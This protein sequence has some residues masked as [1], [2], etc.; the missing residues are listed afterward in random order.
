MFNA[1]KRMK[2]IWTQNSES[3]IPSNVFA[4]GRDEHSPNELE[5]T[6]CWRLQRRT[7]MHIHLAIHISQSFQ[8][9]KKHCKHCKVL[10]R[11]LLKMDFWAYFSKNLTNPA[12]NFCVFG[13]KKLFHEIFRK[14][15]KIFLRKL[16]KMHYFS[17]FFK[18]FNKPSV[19]ILRV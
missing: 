19:Q 12:F 10:L 1:D 15:S 6:V 14:F 7:W 9:K 3:H 11:K 5:L 8:T 4:K 17:I 16:R 13:G 18:N 2:K